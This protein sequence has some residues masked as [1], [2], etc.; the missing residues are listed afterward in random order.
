ME[1]LLNG[2]ELASD[3]WLLLDGLP[4]LPLAVLS[5]AAACLQAVFAR[6]ASLLVKI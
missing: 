6:T 4:S 5:A 2:A 3:S 1:R